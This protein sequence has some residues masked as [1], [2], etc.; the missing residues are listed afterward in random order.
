MSEESIPSIPG[1]EIIPMEAPVML[2]GEESIHMDE[3]IINDDSINETASAPQPVNDVPVEI[4]EALLAKSDGVNTDPVDTSTPAKTHEIK[5][6]YSFKATKWDDD[7]ITLSFPS[8]RQKQATHVL[9][10][11]P[12]INISGTPQIADWADTLEAGVDLLPDFEQF[13][14][15]VDDD[16]SEFSQTV[17]FKGAEY[18]I[19]DIKHNFSNGPVSGEKAI[20]AF[21]KALGVGGLTQVPLWSSGLWVTFKTPSDAD[22]IALSLEINEDKIEKGRATKGL[23]F[24]NVMSYT[25]ERLVRFA[26][27][28][29]Y[30]TTLNATGS[31]NVDLRDL[32][33]VQDYPILVW[34]LICSMYPRG[35]QYKRACMSDPEKCN[36]VLEEVLNPKRLMWTNLRALDDYHMTHMSSRLHKVKTLESVKTYQSSLPSNSDK[37]FTINGDEFDPD[38]SPLIITLKTPSVLEYVVSGE[39]WIGSIQQIVDKLISKDAADKKKND[40][41]EKYAQSSSLK[42]IA[43]WIKSIESNGY[44]ASDKD[45]IGQVLTL[46]S[47]EDDKR[48]RII[49]EVSKY[50]DETTLSVIGVP[51][52]A[53]PKC[54][55]VQKEESMPVSFE[56]IIPLDVAFIFFVL[57]VQRMMKVGQR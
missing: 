3:P 7:A 18:G 27:D 9:D 13:V 29:I 35:F 10:Q 56:N 49:D 19:G 53:C 52:Y 41:I 45:T 33:K 32:I 50:I 14:A 2:P 24:S 40:L 31:E 11:M 5:Y 46:L 25:V 20:L 54:K 47:Q 1:E 38:R 36:Y 16:K 22:L 51:S 21:S 6:Q 17:P 39:E 43:H 42:Q 8:V 23:V 28:H 26:M 48:A 57:S 4:P 12:N 55:E 44:V 15:T 34:G 37:T 30:D